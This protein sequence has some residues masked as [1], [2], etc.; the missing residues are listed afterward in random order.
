[1]I[2]D[3]RV[4]VKSFL[5][6]LVFFGLIPSLGYSAEELKIGI[7]DLPRKLQRELPELRPDQEI[8]FGIVKLHP[9]FTTRMEYDDNVTLADKDDKEDVSFTQIPGMVVEMDFS[10]HRFEA[11]YGMELTNYVKFDD[12]NS[13]NHLAHGILE[14]NFN[15]LQ[16]TARDLFER[17]TS[18]VFT[19]ASERDK[20]LNN[21]VEVASRYDR[22]KWAAEF[23]WR[24]NTIDHLESLSANDYEED[25]LGAL[26]GYKILPKTLMLIEV[27]IGQVVY[28]RTGNAN[29]DFW[30]IY[31][32]FRG[33]PNDEWA[34]TIKLGFQDRQLGDVPGQGSQSDFDGLVADVDLL[35]NPTLTDSFRLGYVR[36][37][38]TSTFADNS[39]FRRDRI[40]VSYSKRFRQKWIFTP[41]F[42]WQF[43]DYPEEG[44][45][46]GIT[47]RRD[48]FYWQT[49]VELR[50]E[51]QRWLS[52]SMAYRFRARNSNLD[53]FDFENNRL[54]FDITFA[55]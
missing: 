11:G 19:E 45:A 35:Y 10:D 17:S 41:Q 4:G 33:E 29:Q 23:A 8:K 31:G 18:R 53:T 47:K 3:K 48:D 52:M 22:P 16:I 2:Q 14:L 6:F 32:G 49:A 40:F 20:L 42:G 25:A 13:V 39:W 46:G 54:T 30:Q 44:T 15:D 9:F 12:E 38:K 50:Y 7:P 55:Y 27:D 24:H 51:I 37:V 1:M 28:D 5:A 34:I 21:A 43:H 26:A 36:M